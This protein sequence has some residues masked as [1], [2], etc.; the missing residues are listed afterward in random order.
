[1]DHILDKKE[2][3][4]LL[5]E[6]IKI[7]NEIIDLDDTLYAEKKIEALQQQLDTMRAALPLIIGKCR[8]T[9]LEMDNDYRQY[10]GED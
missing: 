6:I 5:I 7:Y 1:M 9:M 4:D 2:H 8:F 10:L 3:Q